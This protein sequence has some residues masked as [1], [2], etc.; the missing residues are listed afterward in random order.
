MKLL[1]HVKIRF[2]DMNEMDC[3]FAKTWSLKL[4]SSQ[5]NK[6]QKSWS[7]I[8]EKMKVI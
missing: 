6:Q 5:M 8:E 3:D 4:K 7:K 2:H 1:K